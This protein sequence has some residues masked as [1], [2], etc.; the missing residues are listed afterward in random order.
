MTTTILLS[1][2]MRGGVV[3]GGINT[4]NIKY[5]IIVLLILCIKF[6][7]VKYM[8]SMKLWVF[9]GVNSSGVSRQSSND[10]PLQSCEQL[11]TTSEC[12]TCMKLTVV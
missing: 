10:H 3:E 7:D 8:T 1:N 5:D 4:S 6:I 12:Q 9:E 11:R 2:E